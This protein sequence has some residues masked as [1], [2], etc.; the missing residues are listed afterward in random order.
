MK[1]F[2]FQYP[3]FQ[4]LPQT[5]FIN[6]QKKKFQHSLQSAKTLYCHHSKAKEIMVKKNPVG[7]TLKTRDGL[8]REEER[9]SFVSFQINRFKLHLFFSFLIP[10]VFVPFLQFISPSVYR[11]VLCQNQLSPLNKQNNIQ[12]VTHPSKSTSFRHYLLLCNFKLE[13]T[14]CQL[15]HV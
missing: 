10:T 14:L 4:V 11:T 9:I 1:N 8:G 2:L 15:F 12:S 6:S 5:R 13:I 3:S 7:K